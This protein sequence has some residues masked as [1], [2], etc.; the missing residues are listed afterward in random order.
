MNGP[1]DGDLP[2]PQTQERCSSNAGDGI[3]LVA[4]FRPLKGVVV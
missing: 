3:L 4:V 1:A 2:V